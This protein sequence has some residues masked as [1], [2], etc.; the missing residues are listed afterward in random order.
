MRWLDGITDSMDMNVSKLRET[1]KD[2][3][4]WRQGPPK[5]SGNGAFGTFPE[6]SLPTANRYH[7]RE[8]FYAAQLTFSFPQF[9][10]VAPNY[11][12][13]DRPAGVGDQSLACLSTSPPG[14]VL[15]SEWPT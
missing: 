11:L 4:A 12:P 1:L 8:G 5:S 6:E 9:Q 10:L 3:A 7:C 15:P 2:R 14:K 13:L